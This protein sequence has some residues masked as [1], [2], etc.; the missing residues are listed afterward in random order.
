MSKRH[1]A[2][3]RNT[4]ESRNAAESGNSRASRRR[5]WPGRDGF[6]LTEIMV[7]LMILGIGIVPLA[8]VQ[9]R[10]RTEVTRSDHLTQAVVLGQTQLELMKGAGFGNAAPDSGQADQLRWWTNVQNVSF[11]LDRIEV[12]VTWFDGARD[13]TLQMSSLLSMR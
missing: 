1:P 7:V 13:Q 11:G 2:A 6:S 5:R 3:S 4:S 9:S 12:T 8:M 10:A